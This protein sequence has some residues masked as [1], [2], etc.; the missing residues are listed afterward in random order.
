MSGFAFLDIRM[1]LCYIAMPAD[2][3]TSNFLMTFC[4][5]HTYRPKSQQKCIFCATLSGIPL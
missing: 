3:T 2:V 1:R 4:W 5:A